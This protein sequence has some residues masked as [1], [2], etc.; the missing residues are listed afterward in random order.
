MIIQDLYNSIMYKDKNILILV[1]ARGGSK[2][3]KDKNLQIVGGETLV[4]RSVR[5]AKGSRLADRVVVSTNNCDIKNEAIKKNCE[6]VN[7]PEEIS[8]PLS[9]TEETMIHSLSL[10]PCDFVVVLQPTSPFRSEGLVDRCIKKIIDENADS[11]VA[12]WKF[13]NFC[14]YQECENCEWKS[15]YNYKNR[16]MHEQLS[17]S[18]FHFFDCGNLYITKTDFLVKSKCRL[19]G[20]VIV[21]EVSILENIQID[22]QYELDICKKI[23]NT[24]EGF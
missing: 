15:T 23:G 24:L 21:E 19:G 20:K 3:I 8:G 14:F 16:L 5:H 10:V 18:D 2:S 13:H 7:R 1:P 17:V 12:C 4:A 11:L 22:S 6:V 9:S